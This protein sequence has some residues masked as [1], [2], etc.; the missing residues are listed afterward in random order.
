LSLAARVADG[1]YCAKPAVARDIVGQWSIYLSLR[2]PIIISS[3]AIRV[4]LHAVGSDCDEV[5]AK[6][7]EIIHA[8]VWGTD[9]ALLVWKRMWRG[10]WMLYVKRKQFPQTVCAWWSCVGRVWKILWWRC[11]KTEML[12]WELLRCQPTSFTITLSLIWR[13]I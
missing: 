5:R 8:T 13:W 9:I 12:E 3:I 2:P 7:S 10:G 11:M 4:R 6:A 1:K